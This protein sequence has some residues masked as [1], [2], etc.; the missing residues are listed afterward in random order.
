MP[1]PS[2]LS[3]IAFATVLLPDP[4]V[5]AIKIVGAISTSGP[6]PILWV[7]ISNSTCFFIRQY[8]TLIYSYFGIA[9]HTY[10]LIEMDK[11]D[12]VCLMR[13]PTYYPELSRDGA[14]SHDVSPYDKV[15]E[16]LAD[17]DLADDINAGKATVA[18]LRPSLHEAVVHQDI[19]DKEASDIVERGIQNLGIALKFSV[20]LDKDLVDEFYDGPPK[21]DSML[22]AAP[23]RH[24]EYDNRWDEFVNLMTEGP[25]TIMILKDDEGEAV[26]KWRSQLGH[27]DVN[28]RRDPATLRGIHA[29]DN[30]NNLLHGS[31]STTA[32]VREIDLISGFLRR[33]INERKNNRTE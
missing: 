6:K 25:S 33:K 7:G 14:I 8:E 29:L 22:P 21:Y 24:T 3:T 27:W 20:Q 19:T 4:D 1:D 11:Y 16:Y 28:N 12:K 9:Y 18:M 30:Y 5:P 26:P 32:V 10:Q 17:P 2:T 15:L 31:D 23:E 13:L